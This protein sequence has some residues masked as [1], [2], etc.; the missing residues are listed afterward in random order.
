MR[1]IGSSP[2]V[3]IEEARTAASKKRWEQ[4]VEKARLQTAEHIF[5]KITN[6]I[7]GRA[8]IDGIG[9]PISSRKSFRF[10]TSILRWTAI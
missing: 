7:N 10:P 5:P 4:V 2:E 8:R 6:V 1:N 9:T 3:L